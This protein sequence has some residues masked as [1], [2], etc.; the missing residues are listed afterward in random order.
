MKIPVKVKSNISGRSVE[1]Y[2]T[3]RKLLDLLDEAELID[4]LISCDCQPVGETYVVECNCDDDEEWKD[5]EVLI[6]DEVTA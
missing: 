1:G 4:E 6:G 5:C 2:V 3:P